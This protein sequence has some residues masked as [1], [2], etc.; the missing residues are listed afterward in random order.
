M[1]LPYVPE[2]FCA[3]H[4]RHYDVEEDRVRPVPFDGKEPLLPIPGDEYLVPLVLE[5]FR[6][7]SSHGRFVI[8][9]QNS[10]AFIPSMDYQG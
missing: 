1:C 5:R 9:D 10:H 6:D 4:I 7:D 2:H 3:I 8:N